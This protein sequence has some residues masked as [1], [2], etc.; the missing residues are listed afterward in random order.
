MTVAEFKSYLHEVAGDFNPPL[1]QETDIDAW[2]DRMSEYGRLLVE[3]DLT[4][5]RASGILSGYFNR[6]EQ[7]YAFISIFHVRRDARRQG[8]GRNLMNRAVEYARSLGFST[9]RLNVKKNNSNAITFYKH[10]GFNAIGA[11]DRRYFMEY[12]LKGI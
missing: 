11:D 3:Y 4:T 7:G 9:L 5:S 8:V 2:C 10:Y 12:N 1:D 6:A